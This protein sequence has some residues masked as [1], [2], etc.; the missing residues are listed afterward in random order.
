M[1]HLSETE[2]FNPTKQP[3]LILSHSCTSLN[4]YE[5]PTG[6][7][8]LCRAVTAPAPRGGSCGHFRSGSSPGLGFSIWVFG[9]V[10]VFLPPVENPALTWV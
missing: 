6:T 10:G 5:H 3:W 2:Q 8:P 1:Q 7:Q 4:L 9:C